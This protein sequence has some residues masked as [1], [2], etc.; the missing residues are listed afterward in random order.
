MET[1]K[2]KTEEE[3]IAKIKAKFPKLGEEGNI[4]DYEAN[5]ELKPS[6]IK[7]S[8]NNENGT[9][10]ETDKT[11]WEAYC[12]E[13]YKKNAKYPDGVESHRKETNNVDLTSASSA[14]AIKRPEIPKKKPV[15]ASYASSDED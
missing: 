5:Y 6:T 14:Y 1:I 7:K 15:V 9:G 4:L 3:I 8:E 10:F 11:E 2:R 13:Y 12:E